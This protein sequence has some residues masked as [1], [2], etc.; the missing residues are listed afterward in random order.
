MCGT[1]VLYMCISTED[2][3]LIFSK[4]IQNR[5]F[6]EARWDKR[7]CYGCDGNLKCVLES[8]YI[9]LMTISKRD[10]Q[11][12]LSYEDRHFAPQSW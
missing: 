8:I 2:S 7:L 4:R 12:D 5:R 3:T 10:L 6:R 11:L 9:R 1:T